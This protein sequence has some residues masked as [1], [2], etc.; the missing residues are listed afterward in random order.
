MK[1]N[2]DMIQYSIREQLKVSSQR[3]LSF[4][5]KESLKVKYDH[6]QMPYEGYLDNLVNQLLIS[7]STNSSPSGINFSQSYL[8]ICRKTKPS[9]IKATRTT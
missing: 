3:N 5:E 6:G 8:R 4:Q 1:E 2:K 7:S 9:A